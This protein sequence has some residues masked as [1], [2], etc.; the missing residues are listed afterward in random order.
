MANFYRR[1]LPQ[2]EQRISNAWKPLAFFSRKFTPAQSAYSTYDRELTAIFEV[3]KYFRHFLDGQNFSVIADHKPLMY[4]LSQNSFKASPR[5]Q[6]QLTYISQFTSSILYQ[7]GT[8]NVVADSLSRV[9]TIRLPTEW[10]LFELTD[11]QK[12][13]Q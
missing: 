6:R 2:L 13:D 9:E 11:A 3:I 8:E 4:A 7:P 1:N 5:Q 12:N 10:N